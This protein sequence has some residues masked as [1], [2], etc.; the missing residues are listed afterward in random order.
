VKDDL[1]FLLY[2]QENIRRIEEDTAGG[3]AAF[4]A[5]HT[6]QDAS[7]IISNRLPNRQSVFLLHEG[8]RIRKWIGVESPASATFLCM[9]T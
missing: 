4:D 1:K 2:I 8:K 5:S 7:Y 9:T 3:R 6:V